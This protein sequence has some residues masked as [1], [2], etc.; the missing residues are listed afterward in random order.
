MSGSK[1]AYQGIDKLR[2]TLRKIDPDMAKPVRAAV[3]DGARAIE[4]NIL[5]DVPVDQGD[6]Q[7]SISYKLGRDGF[8]AYVGA[9]AD[10]ASIVKLGF[11][12]AERKYTKS[13]ALTKATLANDDALFQAY[14]LH[15]L[16]EGTK[17]HG[18]H[19]GTPALHIKK[20]AFDATKVWLQEKLKDAIDEALER[21]SR[22]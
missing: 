2:R 14:K 5:R 6:L 1:R 12:Q 8:S 16:E 10:R 17:P 20:R 15:W 21:A 18:G 11:G 22:G 9:G 19:P 4:F 13:G 7:R 3:E